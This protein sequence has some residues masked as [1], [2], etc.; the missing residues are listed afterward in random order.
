MPVT[1]VKNGRAQLARD[2][3]ESHAVCNWHN[4][5]VPPSG[6]VGY[7]RIPVP[8]RVPRWHQLA[9]GKGEVTLFANCDN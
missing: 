8:L 6:H 3:I 1:L 4:E 2:S 9:L 7:L 5:H